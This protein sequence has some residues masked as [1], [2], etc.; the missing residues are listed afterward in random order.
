MNAKWGGIPERVPPHNSPTNQGIC[1]VGENST[2]PTDSPREFHKMQNFVLFMAP[3][4]AVAILF[5]LIAI[6]ISG[7]DHR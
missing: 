6:G 2:P 4:L 3:A 7:R 5:T 1:K